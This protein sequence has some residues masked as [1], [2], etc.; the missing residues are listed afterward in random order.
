MI[1]E[2]LQQVRERINHAARQA[3]RDPA[4]ITLV[5][6]T[7]THP[8]ELIAEVL[9]AGVLDCGENRVQEATSK[10]PALANQGWRPRWHLIGHLQRNKARPAADL[11]DLV[12]SVD[13]LRLAEVLARQVGPERRLPILLQVNVSGEASKDG[14]EL[15][16]GTTN[17][18]AL[19]SFLPAVEAILALPSLE[20]RG[21]MTIAPFGDDPEQARPSFAALRALRDK[22]VRRYPTTGWNELSMGMTDDFEVA[23]AEGATLVRVGRAIFGE[24]G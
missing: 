4:T 10:I 9:Q 19:D 23:I 16:G 17:Q 21:L 22:L 1:A 5:A 14:F 24:R 6:V 7:K 12:H 18:A 11:F 13:S 20:V 3:G 8:P 2:R 15:P